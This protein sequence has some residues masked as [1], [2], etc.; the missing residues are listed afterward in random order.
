MVRLKDLPDYEQEHLMN[1]L[2]PPLGPLPWIKPKKNLNEMK[3]AILTTAGLNYRN[4]DNFNFTDASFRAIP[5]ETESKN[6]LMTHSSVNF[7]RSGFQ[8]DLNVVF[9]IERFKELVDEGFIGSIAVSYTHLTLPTI[10]S[11]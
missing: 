2:L 7:D 11:V 4:E 5:I 1:K 6:L 3:I 10:C 9:P 8:E